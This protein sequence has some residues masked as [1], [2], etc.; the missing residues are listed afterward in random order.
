MQTNYY[1][2]IFSINTVGLRQH[3]H[4]DYLLHP[5]RTD[6]IGGNGTGKSMVGDLLQL[7]FICKRDDWRPGTEGV[8]KG[9]RKIETIPLDRAFIKFGYAFINIEREKGKFITIGVFIQR[10]SAPI[11][12]FII[13]RG[14]DFS[15][16]LLSF[17]HPIVSNDF[18]DEEGHLVSV[19]EGQL[20]THLLNKKGLFVKDFFRSEGISQYYDLLLK[21][22]IIDIDLNRP[23]NYASYAKVLQSFSRA[24]T[25][26]IA[27]S[28]SLKDFL[29]EDTDGL[30]KYFDE[31]KDKLTD[32]MSDYKKYNV[33]VKLLSAKQEKLTLLKNLEIQKKEAQFQLVLNDAHQAWLTFTKLESEKNDNDERWHKSV[34]EEIKIKSTLDVLDIDLSSKNAEL[35]V[36]DKQINDG[37]QYLTLKGEINNIVDQKFFKEEQINGFTKQLVTLTELVEVKNLELAAISKEERTSFENNKLN[38]LQVT[39]SKLLRQTE[40]INLFSEVLKPYKSLSVLF[41]DYNRQKELIQTLIQ[42]NNQKIKDLEEVLIL[43]EGQ[44]KDNLFQWAMQNDNALSMV[45][46]SILM[47]FKSLLIQKPALV[48]LGK[49]YILSPI[50]ILSENNILDKTEDGFWFKMGEIVEYIPYIVKQIFNKKGKFSEIIKKDSIELTKQIASLKTLKT[51]LINRDALIL[52]QYGI[53]QEI[54]NINDEDKLTYFYNICNNQENIKAELDAVSSSIK[55]SLERFGIIKERKSNLSQELLQLNDQQKSNTELSALLEKEINTLKDRE[56][57]LLERISAIRLQFDEVINDLDLGVQ[58]EANRSHKELLRSSISLLQKTRNQEN[59]KYIEVVKTKASAEAR[60]KTIDNDFSYAKDQF[61]KKSEQYKNHTQT[62][63]NP[64]NILLSV[65]AESV[66]LTQIRANAIALDQNYKDVF[67]QIIDTFEETKN[68]RNE[69]LNEHPFDFDALQTVLLGS[70]IRF[71]DNITPELE[72][73]NALLSN[74]ANLQTDMVFNVFNRV[75]KLFNEYEKNVRDLNFFFQDRKISNSFILHID[76]KPKKELLTEGREAVFI[77]WIRKMKEKSQNY[78]FGKN[79]FTQ[80]IPMSPDELIISIVRQFYNVKDVSIEELLNPKYYFDLESKF[81]NP[82]SGRESGSAGQAYT[83]IVLLCIGRLSILKDKTRSMNTGVRFVILEEVAALDETNFKLAGEEGYQV[84]T[85]NPEPYKCYTE[86]GW[87]IHMLSR[88]KKHFDV[89]N[90]PLSLFR[91]KGIKQELMFENGN[92]VVGK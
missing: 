68:K 12:P 26:N 39:Q 35:D 92:V 56:S 9:L 55:D 20:K 80:D 36:L 81:L 62:D 59:D 65:K 2:R 45:Q 41:E 28:R 67:N 50:Q 6:F 51:N 87:Y 1:P 30:K 75:D 48:G 73:L 86:D 71:M 13:Q 72:K 61:E 11:R 79:L 57:K 7:I 44:E 76:F 58:I 84:V 69:V 82:Q 22:G 89:N 77:D 37:Q 21:N 14:E 40:D 27:N 64:D 53:K 70:K 88:G 54:I 46:E 18:L 4:S 91:K 43:F 83:A 19:L 49:K 17:N 42:E 31:E 24:K 60:R 33:Q 34:Q 25:L 29:F 74:I 5:L 90:H 16:T 78:K 47:H 23:G 15:S 66:N 10:N 38:E 63:F 32:L 3:Y 85:M 52:A 8:E